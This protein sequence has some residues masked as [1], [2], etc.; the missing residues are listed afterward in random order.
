MELFVEKYR[1]QKIEDCILPKKTKDIFL[2]YVSEGNFQNLL[3]CGSAGCGKTTVARALC[4]EINAE[5]LFVN[6]SEE[7][8]IDV[9]RTKIRRFASSCSMSGEPKVV[10]L[11]EADYLNCFSGIQKIQIVENGKISTKSIDELKNSDFSAISYN[12][13]TGKDEIVNAN[14]FESGE[15]EVFEVEFEDGTKIQCTKD[16]EFFDEDGNTV[17]INDKCALF[18]N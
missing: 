8:G 10:I 2:K 12:F 15:A 1:P 6:A 4:N 16:H 5:I 18:S 3:L 14:V 9:L 13:D 7:S 17:K 11:D